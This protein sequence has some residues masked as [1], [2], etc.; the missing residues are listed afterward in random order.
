[1]IECKLTKHSDCS[2]KNLGTKHLGTKPVSQ[3]VQEVDE[4]KQVMHTSK[5]HTS[6]SATGLR[7][8]CWQHHSSPAE[9]AAGGDE[10]GQE[11]QHPLDQHLTK[12]KNTT[13]LAHS[14][15]TH[16][17]TT[18]KAIDSPL[19][20]EEGGKV[21]QTLTRRRRAGTRSSLGEEGQAPG[22]KP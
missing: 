15:E 13:V 3:H 2:D 8:S 20:A 16:L 6:S 10:H 7:E 21:E 17:N 18:S 4:I 9:P 19:E 22:A 14:I 5:Q 1:M 12:Y 11:E